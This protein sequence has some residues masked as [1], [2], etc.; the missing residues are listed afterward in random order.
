MDALT[1]IRTRRSLPKLGLPVPTPTQ[2]ATTFE[3][4]ASAPDH[5]VLRPWRYLVIEGDGLA[6]LGTVFVDA[7]AQTD[8][9]RAEAAG[10]R[11]RQMPL[12]APMIIVAILSLQDH[13]GVPEWEQ[14]LS[15][16]ASVQNLLLALHAQGFAGMWRTGDM[17]TNRH[18]CA[19][20]GLAVHEHIG[21]L[22]YVGSAQAE[23]AAPALPEKLWT[24]WPA[25]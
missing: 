14:W 23:K 15:L 24:P 6:Q 8:A 12:R 1:A 4:A 25:K 3:A 22:I 9:A 10:E 18:V 11:F 2:L 20:L 5:R 7:I 17:A 21:G 19:E 16:G 13:P